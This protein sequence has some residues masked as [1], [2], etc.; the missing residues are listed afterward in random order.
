MTFLDDLDD[1]MRSM[2]TATDGGLS[3]EAEYARVV[4]RKA[5]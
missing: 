1:L 2:N 4:A 5:G 3:Y